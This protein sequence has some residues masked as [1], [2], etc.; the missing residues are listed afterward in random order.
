ME[1]SVQRPHIAAVGAA[2]Q[3][4]GRRQD[5]KDEIVLEFNPKELA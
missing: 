2:P 5:G 4:D 3:V 1:H